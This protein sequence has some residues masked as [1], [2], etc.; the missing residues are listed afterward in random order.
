MRSHRAG[1]AA[2]IGVI[3]QKWTMCLRL[4]RKELKH[5][6]LWARPT[7]G[8]VLT[9]AL[10]SAV[11]LTTGHLGV[12]GLGYDDLS[13]GLALQL[14]WRVA[15]ILLGA[16]LIATVLCYG[17]GGCGGIFSPTLFLGGMCGVC[18]SGLLGLAFPLGTA[19]QVT[20][21]VIG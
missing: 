14:G 11:F 18:L 5:L 7:L 17:L 1:V 2:V 8:A 21:A 4:R 12:F 10:G 16:K 19:D 20:L 6:P 15:A 13:A 9:W 3:F